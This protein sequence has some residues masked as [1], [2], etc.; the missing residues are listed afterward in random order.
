MRGDL[1]IGSMVAVLVAY[2]DLAGPWKELLRYYQRK[3][4]IR[5]KYTQVIEQ[6]NPPNLI[7]PDLISRDSETQQL[8]SGG[9]TANNIS[10]TEDGL[11]F[12]VEGASFKFPLDQHTAAV[13]MG[14]SGKDELATLLSRLVNP[15]SGTI[16]MG[17]TN[18]A[19]L[20][21]ALTGRRIGY[22]GQNAYLFTGSVRDNLLYPLKN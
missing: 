17:A 15:S 7:E 3:E 10:Y 14:N 13:G 21:E 6:F 19:E 18:M 12:S 16:T 4:D 2:K 8:P 11:Y 20:P 1:S 5:V 22:V 9:L